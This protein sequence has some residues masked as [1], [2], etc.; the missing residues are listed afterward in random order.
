MVCS[1][2]AAK[3]TSL[4]DAMFADRDSP[5]DACPPALPASAPQPRSSETTA[6]SPH[7]S[8]LLVVRSS[9]NREQQRTRDAAI[10]SRACDVVHVGFAACTSAALARGDAVHE[11]TPRTAHR[12]LTL[13]AGVEQRTPANLTLTSVRGAEPSAR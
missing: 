5:W 6:H 2:E 12:S 8:S 10:A 13:K 11:R 7:T 3:T 1:A 4:Y 9:A